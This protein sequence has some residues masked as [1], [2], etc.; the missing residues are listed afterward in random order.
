MKFKV[1]RKHGRLALGTVS[2]VAL[3]DTQVAARRHFA[4]VADKVNPS[5]ERAKAIVKV[6]ETLADHIDDFLTYL[7]DDKQRDPRHVHEVER[8]VRRSFAALHRFN[9]ADVDRAMVSKQLDRIKVENGPSAAK[10]SRSHLSTYFAWL[11]M[12]GKHR[13]LNPVDG[14]AKFGGKPRKRLLKPNEVRAIWAALPPP[15]DEVRLLFLVGVSREE[16][17]A[18]HRDEI[19]FKAKQLE[20]PGVRTKSGRD[21]IVPLSP[22]ALAILQARVSH[23]GFIFGRGQNG[24]SAW[25]W[26]KAR[27]DE[28]SY[29]HGWVLHDARR[30]MSTTMNEVLKIEPHVVGASLGHVTGGVAGIYNRAAYVKQKRRALQ[31]YADYLMKLVA[32]EPARPRRSKKQEAAPPAP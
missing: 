15:G 12:T 30:L 23:T 19:N 21:F 14:T 11:F 22:P 20:I 17:G 1:G 4:S 2:K 7:R 3:V 26:C 10:H 8:S 24:F 31:R 6:N 27:L 13:G 28:K 25:S 29:T 9:S 16:I 18:L 5:T 32:V